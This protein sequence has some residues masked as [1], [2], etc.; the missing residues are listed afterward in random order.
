MGNLFIYGTN[1]TIVY[2]FHDWTETTNNRPLL[3]AI[4][5]RTINAGMSLLVTNLATD[6][7]LPQQ[8]LT[9][10][11]SIGPTNAIIAT[12]TGI[13]SWRPTMAQ[14]SST[15]PFTM[16][17]ADNGTPS[18][19]A[20]QTFTVTVNVLNRPLLD[21]ASVTNKQIRFQINGDFGPDYTLQSSTNL[22]AW[23]N[24]FTSNSP[25]L[26][27][28]WAETNYQVFPQKFYRILLGP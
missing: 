12:N 4:S 19:S 15:N 18:L 13:L 16:T 3:A 1:R 23:T 26:P 6:A 7:D 17:V 14:A 20:T 9:F 24:L 27:L 22:A 25:A 8:T 5:N 28:N 2:N 10:G 21:A 11:L